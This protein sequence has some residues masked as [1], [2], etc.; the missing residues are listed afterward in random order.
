V[1][2]PL[3]SCSH[4][5]NGLSEQ[6][7]LLTSQLS[8]CQQQVT[9]LQAELKL[10]QKL[11]RDSGTA[12]GGSGDAGLSSSATLRLLDEV[13]GLRKQLQRGIRNNDALAQQLRSK[14]EP[15]SE[16]EEEEEGDGEGSRS[17]GSPVGE[18]RGGGGRW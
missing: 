5:N 15:Q 13:K 18:R 7:N 2:E 14:L 1:F 16:R 8:S 3:F 6:R 17:S 10:Y 11:V 12:A 4:S 9:A